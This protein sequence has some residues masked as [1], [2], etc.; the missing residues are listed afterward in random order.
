[1]F[2]RGGMSVRMGGAVM[3]HFVQM[4][5]CVVFAESVLR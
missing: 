5:G 2:L 4:N 3:H 1:M